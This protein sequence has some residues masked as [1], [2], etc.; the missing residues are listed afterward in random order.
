L[1]GPQFT[2]NGRQ[3]S[4]VKPSPGPGAYQPKIKTVQ[5]KGEEF[6]VGTS[7]RIL[8]KEL[9][10]NPGPGQHAHFSQLGGPKFGMGSEKRRV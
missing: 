1:R 6:K 3:K 8:L 2:A 9:N 4:Y 5:K 7:K 10:N